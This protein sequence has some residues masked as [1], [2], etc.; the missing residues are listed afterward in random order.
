MGGPE[1][2]L[3]GMIALCLG[4]AFQLSPPL[5]SSR[6][7]SVQRTSRILKIQSN[8]KVRIKQRKSD[9]NRLA[10]LKII[11]LNET[12]IWMKFRSPI[13]EEGYVVKSEAG[14][15]FPTA[16][17]TCIYG[18]VVLKNDCPSHIEVVLG[19]PKGK[20]KI[21]SVPQSDNAVYLLNYNNNVTL[22]SVKNTTYSKSDLKVSVRTQKSIGE[23]HFNVK[24][25][26]SGAYFSGKNS[27]ILDGSIQP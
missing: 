27:I 3:E 5:S 10:S 14:Y 9:I 19:F 17:Q 12:P 21:F 23:V 8:F 7:T 2:I 6:V 16:F 15:I 25:T 22:K 1:D 4:L 13:I 11:G 18:S 26:I 20:Q 24:S